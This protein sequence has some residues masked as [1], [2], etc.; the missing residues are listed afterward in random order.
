[1]AGA[2]CDRHAAMQG[3]S[4]SSRRRAMARIA[5]LGKSKRKRKWMKRTA[6]LAIGRACRCER[7]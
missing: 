6:W 3:N 7:A 2:Q 5:V 4:R 1:M